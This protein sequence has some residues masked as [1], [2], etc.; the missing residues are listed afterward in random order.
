[1][2]FEFESVNHSFQAVSQDSELQ[3]RSQSDTSGELAD[4]E[5]EAVAGGCGEQNRTNKDS[6]KAKRDGQNFG[7]TLSVPFKW[8]GGV[9]D[10]FFD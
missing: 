10:G 1:M 7:D 9:W 4:S 8:A 5:L 3:H 6:D 2:S